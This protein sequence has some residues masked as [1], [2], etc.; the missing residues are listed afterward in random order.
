[1]YKIDRGGGG[2][3][4]GSKNRSL[5]NYR[6]SYLDQEN[7]YILLVAIHVQSFVENSEKKF[8]QAQKDY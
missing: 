7:S 5:G 4:G 3:M 2:H 8:M 6:L 1:M